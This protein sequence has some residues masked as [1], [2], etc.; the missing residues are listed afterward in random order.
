MKNKKPPR[1]VAFLAGFSVSVIFDFFWAYIYPKMGVEWN[2][3]TRYAIELTFLFVVIIAVA[4]FYKNR[5][6]RQAEEA[7]NAA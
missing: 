6:K 4:L 2:V 1:W 5:E 3:Y 7:N